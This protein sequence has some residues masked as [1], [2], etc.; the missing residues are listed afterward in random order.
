MVRSGR[1][2]QQAVVAA[3]ALLIDGYREV[4]DADLADYFGSIPHAKL[5]RSLAGRIVDRRA[6]HLIKKSRGA[7]AWQRNTFRRVSMVGDATR[8]AERRDPQEAERHE[9]Q[10]LARGVR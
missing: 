4:V 7:L 2:A 9:G 10:D 6:L 5:M 8:A 1:N 3:E